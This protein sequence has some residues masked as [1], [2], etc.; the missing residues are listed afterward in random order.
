MDVLEIARRFVDER[1]PTATIA[2]VGGSSARGTRTPTSDIDMLV[3]APS[4][5]FGDGSDSLAA[6]Y[7]FE[8]E[9]VE[10]FAYTPDAFERWAEHDLADYRPVLHTLLMEGV[11]LV[12]ADAAQTLRDRWR[13]RVEAGPQVTAHGLAMR[14]YMITDLLDDLLDASDPAEQTYLMAE[15]YGG[16]AEA[17]LLT[18]R[19]W[20]GGGKWL[21]RRLREWDPR[22]AGV[23]TEALVDG[24]PARFARVASEELER[25]GGRVQTGFAR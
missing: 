1:F 12:G 4:P 9:A 3:I 6:S 16:L 19:R 23:L 2:I 22:R 25:I 14:R 5:A 24:D 11:V 20:L 13:P 21:V 17:I 7:A 18:E 10:V 8:D 15:L